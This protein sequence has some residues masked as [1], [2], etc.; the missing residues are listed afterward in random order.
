MWKRNAFFEDMS[1]FL[2]STINRDHN[3]FRNR[4]SR[5]RIHRQTD[6]KTD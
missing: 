3:N 5:E 2:G 1:V 4:A 6:R